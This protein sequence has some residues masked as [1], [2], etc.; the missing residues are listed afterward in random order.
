MCVMFVIYARCVC[1]LCMNVVLCY[2]K[3]V[4]MRCTYVCNPCLY[5]CVCMYVC[6]CVRYSR[7]AM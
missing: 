7:Y 1:P 5:D 3:R 4:S 6:L 2:V